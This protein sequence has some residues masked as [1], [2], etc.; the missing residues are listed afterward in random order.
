MSISPKSGAT[1]LKKLPSLKYYNVLKLENRLTL[2][3][4][5]AKNS[6]YMKKS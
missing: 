1:V 5:A 3:L 2:W 6:D 4:N